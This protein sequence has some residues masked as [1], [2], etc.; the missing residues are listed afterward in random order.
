M[1]NKFVLID[2]LKLYLSKNRKL[3]TVKYS[4]PRTIFKYPY[5]KLRNEYLYNCTHKK[6]L[7]RSNR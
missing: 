2:V 6:T 3:P 4:I 5:K 1:Q 7:Y